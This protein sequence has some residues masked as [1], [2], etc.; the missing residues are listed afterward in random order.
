MSM[1][2][3]SHILVLQ[4]RRKTLKIGRQMQMKHVHKYMKIHIEI[5]S[6]KP[7]IIVKVYQT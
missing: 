2:L 5:A 4:L 6:T 7:A 3:V 1:L